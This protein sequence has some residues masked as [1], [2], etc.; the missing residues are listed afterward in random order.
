[1][2]TTSDAV[3]R[4]RQIDRRRQ[5]LEKLV[6]ITGGD[7]E[8]GLDFGRHDAVDKR[9]IIVGMGA[10]DVLQAS[11]LWLRGGALH[12]L[13]HHLQDVRPAAEAALLEQRQGRAHF[14]TLWH[15]LEDARLENW[16]EGAGRACGAP[17]RRAGFPIWAEVC[18]S[19]CPRFSS[20]SSACTC[21]VGT[22]T[23]QASVPTLIGRLRTSWNC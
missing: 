14:S 16:M 2:T 23:D 5:R 12:L 18:S 17:L 22:S 6:Q 7:F 13:G 19:A 1:M 20:S 15:A 21:S 4:Q 8:L 3:E 9:R 10:D 11:H